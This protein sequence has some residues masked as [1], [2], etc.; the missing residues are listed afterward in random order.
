VI[1]SANG[2]VYMDWQFHRDERACGTFGVD[3]YI[4][5]TPGDKVEHDTSETGANAKEMYARAH[6]GKPGAQQ[7]APREP[8]RSL[9]RE[10]EE[11]AH[12]SEAPS[13][14]PSAP[15]VI[16]PEVTPEVRSAA[17]GWFAAYTRGDAAWLAGWSATPFTAA[18]EVVARDGTKLKA[19]YKQLLAENAGS[20]KIAG[21]EV[22][23]PAGIRGKLGGLPPGGE[24]S[25]MLYAVGKAGTEEFILLL[26]KSD[27]GWRVCGIDR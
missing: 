2:K 6:E 10:P 25:G 8:P 5:T 11:R 7:Q 16:V 14:R 26:K 23:T 18:G 27:Q 3:P 24:E 12:E 19:I 15:T 17:E 13:V 22:L 20:R 1:K 4:L 21:L 9:Q